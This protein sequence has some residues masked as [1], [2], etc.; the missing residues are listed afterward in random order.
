MKMQEE[1]VAAAAAAAKTEGAFLRHR[2]ISG[3]GEV[4]PRDDLA[5][6]VSPQ[7]SHL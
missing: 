3:D 7:E 6:P 2:P 1:R 5:A 4:V